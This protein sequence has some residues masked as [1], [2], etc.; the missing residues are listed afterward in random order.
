MIVTPPTDEP[1][2]KKFLARVGGEHTLPPRNSTPGPSGN[3]YQNVRS[4]IRSQGGRALLGYEV[5]WLP[6]RFIEALHHCILQRPDGSVLDVTAP[7]YPAMPGSPGLFL[8]RPAQLLG[9]IDPV[10]DS[11]FQQLDNSDET[12]ALIEATIKCSRIL[13]RT[14]SVVRSGPHGFVE[15]RGIQPL[16]DHPKLKQIIENSRKLEEA[17]KRRDKI[18]DAMT[19]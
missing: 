6:G 18:L 4:A 12:A 15:G 17:R 14:L 8:P 5:I 9:K 13:R 16:E 11:I 10:K 1:T 7:P 2:I 3:C 19:S